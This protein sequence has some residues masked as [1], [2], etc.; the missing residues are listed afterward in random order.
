MIHYYII[1]LETT[2]LSSKY[3]E[4]CEIS[5]I[6]A[7]D[8][9][10][11]SRNVIVNFPERANYDALRITS[12]TI[13]DLKRGDRKE[14]VIQECNAFFEADN[15]SPSARCIVG[16]N[17]WSFDRKF[18]YA[19]WE[20]VGKEFP[21]ALWLDSMHMAKEYVKKLGVKRSISLANSCE[22]MGIKKA[23]SAHNA[24]ADSRQTYFLWQKLSEELDYL[25]FIKQDSHSIKN[26]YSVDD[27]SS[28]LDNLNEI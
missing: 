23:A 1:D 20:S 7:S 13:S 18:L 25:P 28:E 27:L 3:H 2:G 26:S 22:M 6:R 19:L 24:K 12:K 21:A 10:Q 16:H 4:V 17:I 14:S 9:N 11:I 5:I 8:K 15:A